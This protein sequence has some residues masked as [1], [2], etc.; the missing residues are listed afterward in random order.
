LFDDET[1]GL[2][3]RWRGFGRSV[4]RIAWNWK[5]HRPFYPNH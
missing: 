2:E 5:C 1:F 3:C 4:R